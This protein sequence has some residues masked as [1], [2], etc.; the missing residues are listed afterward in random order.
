MSFCLPFGSAILWD[1]SSGAE[2]LFCCCFRKLNRF[3]SF[4][5]SVPE[6]PS[7]L[8]F[9]EADFHPSSHAQFWFGRNIVKPAP[10]VLLHPS[11]LQTKFSFTADGCTGKH[12]CS[13]C[14]PVRVLSTEADPGWGGCALAPLPAAPS[15]RAA[16]T[17]AGA[18][19]SSR[20][21]L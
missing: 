17:A 9:G 14:G 12:L 8:R 2:R 11:L 13:E 1:Q 7:F 5:V 3:L 16:F 20:V 4:H 21:V 15:P 19:S 6:R 10:S 18:R